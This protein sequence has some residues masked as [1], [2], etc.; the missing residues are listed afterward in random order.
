MSLT[1]WKAA[2]WLVDHE[3]SQDE[4]RSLLGVIDR[5]LRDSAVA[6]L[7]PDTQLGLAS[8]AHAFTCSATY[9]R[10]RRSRRRRID[11]EPSATQQQEFQH[12]LQLSRGEGRRG[13]P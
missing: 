6:V 10:S 9:A 13:L 11:M 7:S 3:P 8:P 1:D 12:P 2:G 4:T 5:D